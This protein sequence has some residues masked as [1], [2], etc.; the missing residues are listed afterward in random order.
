MSVIDR[1]G[2]FKRRTLRETPTRHVIGTPQPHPVET[3]WLSGTIFRALSQNDRI[4]ICAPPHVDSC[5]VRDRIVRRR[6]RS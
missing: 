1:T 3:T 5:P 6:T 2:E 4:G